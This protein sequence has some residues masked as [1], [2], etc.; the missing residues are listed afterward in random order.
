MENYHRLNYTPKGGA[1]FLLELKNLIFT[2]FTLGLYYPWA[3]ASRLRFH[4]GYTSIGENSF[5]FRGTGNE[6][7]LGFLKAILLLFALEACLI[8]GLLEDDQDLI[9]LGLGILYIGTLFIIPLSLHG[10]MRY[11]L[12]KTSF[13]GIRF[14]YRGDLKELVILMI[15]NFILTLITLGI[16]APWAYVEIR[17]YIMSK[18]RFGSCRFNFDGNGGDLF[19]MYIKAIFLTPLTLGIYLLFFYRNLFHFAAKH[20]TLEH[21][22]QVARF[23]TNFSASD[24]LLIYVL[25]AILLPITIGIGY[26]WIRT[27]VLE[28][29]I[30]SLRIGP[31]D[32]EKVIQTEEKYDD[33]SGDALGDAMDFG[34]I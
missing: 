4:Y 8:Y 33:A 12:A 22:G 15:K 1:F 13:R 19:W 6:M 23:E 9:L 16:Y 14:G 29:V 30:N 27:A 11:R 18:T 5:Q 25:Q 17:K 28:I 34:F 32:L 20:T 3:K 10:T 7:F 24:V 21:E 31:I 26:P 2:L